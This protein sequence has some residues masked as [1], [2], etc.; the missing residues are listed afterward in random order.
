[1]RTCSIR[2]FNPHLPE[3]QAD[4]ASRLHTNSRPSG[5]AQEYSGLGK[6]RTQYLKGGDF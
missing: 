3:R 1:M 6:L 2:G 4:A 5:Q